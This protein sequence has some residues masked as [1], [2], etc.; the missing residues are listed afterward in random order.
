MNETL[1]TVV[2]L[3]GFKLKTDYYNPTNYAQLP[4][5]V[6]FFIAG[7]FP[8]GVLFFIVGVFPVGVLFFFLL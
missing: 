8:V 7:V 3:V 5:R 6:L 1:V 2:F 4:V